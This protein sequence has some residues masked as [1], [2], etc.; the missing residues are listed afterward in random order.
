MTIAPNSTIFGEVICLLLPWVGDRIFYHEVMRRRGHLSDVPR[1]GALSR[2]MR[3]QADPKHGQPFTNVM[4]G[5]LSPEVLRDFEQRA[6]L[7]LGEAQ[8]QALRVVNETVAPV[9]MIRALAGAGKTVVGQVIT[10]AFNRA[11]CAA[12]LD[13]GPGTQATCAVYMV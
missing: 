1:L 12:A 8:L 9:V 10:Y 4:R 5:R 7:R 6:Q 13:P 11:R 3:A 2:I